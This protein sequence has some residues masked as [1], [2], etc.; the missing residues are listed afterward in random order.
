MGQR[1]LTIAGNGLGQSSTAARPD[2]DRP[3]RLRLA[4]LFHCRI[5]EQLGTH[6]LRERD[7]TNS[8]RS[9]CP[10]SGHHFGTPK[11]VP[12]TQ[13]CDE[14]RLSNRKRMSLFADVCRAVQHAHQKGVIHRDL[15]PSNV[16]ATIHNGEPFI[17]IIDFGVAKAINQELTEKTLF[18]SYGQLVGTPQY[19]SPEQAQIS[20]VDVDTRSDVYSL[21][22][23]LF[24]LLTG[25]T[26][27]NPK[28][29]LES[30]YDEM[31][32]IIREEDSPKPSEHL[33]VAESNLTDVAVQRSSNPSGIKRFLAG[34]VDWIVMQSLDKDRDRRYSTAENLAD[35]IERFLN[36]E[37]IEARPPSRIYRLKKFVGKNQGTVVASSVVAAAIIVGLVVTSWALV[38]VKQE[39]ALTTIAKSELEHA[40]AQL[41]VKNKYLRDKFLHEAISSAMSPN[42]DRTLRSLGIAEEAGASESSCEMVRGI[43]ARSEGKLDEA[44][45]LLTRASE[46]DPT[47]LA[48]MCELFGVSFD[49][50]EYVEFNRLKMA[51]FDM[52]PITAED[53]VFKGKAY[54]IMWMHDEALELIKQGKKMHPT[55]LFQVIHADALGDAGFQEQDLNRIKTAYD[56]L[57]DAQSLLGT[58]HAGIRSAML[59]VIRQYVSVARLKNETCDHLIPI[60]DEC[61]D[62]LADSKVPTRQL[63]RA[64][65]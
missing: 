32:R 51:I 21:G 33:R 38:R 58:D 15:K 60:G 6:P 52:E 20:S 57:V 22:V 16:M 10:D 26:P 56:E 44:L 4:R 53:F 11:G 48:A 49:K 23:L 27:L 29:L 40:N 64:L 1:P 59:D 18:T 12:I 62:F 36:G 65:Y 55:P 61:A 43:L 50:G 37:P 34:D 2:A 35:D 25:S 47:N 5:G 8:R 41:S 42:R 19:M 24:E 39:V 7:V 17:K 9:N 3:S 14:N 30:G 13:F 28:R 54:L 63:A 46:L 45:G 31:R